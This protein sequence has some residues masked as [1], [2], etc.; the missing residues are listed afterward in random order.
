VDFANKYFGDNYALVYKKQGQDP[1]EKKIDKP[2]ITP[3]V[4]NRDSASAFLKEIQASQV[5][6]IEPVFL[7]YEKDLQ[8]LTA[9]SNIPVLY[10]ENTTNDLFTLVYVFEMGNNN[11][12]AMSTAVQ[13]MKYLGTSKKS[14]KEINEE[15]Y[16]L[17][18]YFRVSSGA[19][20]SY[21]T[22]QGLKENMPKAM[23]LFEEIL[24]DAQVN[25]EAYANLAA[26]IIKNRVD[27]KLN[28]GQNFNSL[29]QYAIWGPKSPYTN[30]LSSAELKQ[31]NPQEL[32]DRIHN[33][34]T[35]E[36]KILYYGP[37]KPE[38]VLDIIKQYHN[39]PE[40]LQ[41]VPAG[42]TFEQQETPK[43][44]VLL[45][46]YDAKQIYFSAISN[47]G[48][49]FDPAIQPTL[50]MYNEY[51]GGGMNAI[52][53][54]EM[55][56]ARGLAYSAGAFMIVPSKLKYPYVYRTF[57]ATQNDKMIDAMKAF[58]EI[59][60]NMP[61]SEKAFNLAKEAMITRLRTDRVTKAEVLWSYLDAQDLGLTTDSRKDLYEKIQT[62]TLPEI[63]AFQEKW[64]KD[65]TY[66]YCILGD[67]KDL[68]IKSL[69]K[70]GP[71]QRVTKEELFGY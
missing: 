27:A 4:M 28:Q 23:A 16:R 13:Y 34:N 63:K 57:I 38:A 70:Y 43:S 42:I 68:D 65:R 8:K 22:L 20:R 5:A 44:K 36:H 46:Q 52:V 9:K 45:A 51:L 67:E 54:Q 35:F 50:D 11:D 56:E 69:S 21:V 17:A 24:A 2:Q 25:K 58:D 40:Q 19:E 59:I 3:I 6:P 32:V 31:M 30:V 60:N 64:V 55:R 71:I 18:C 12:K 53:F 39:V 37:E 10:K 66:I 15:F 47:R 1:N 29:V 48:E 61:E 62:M 14:L 26:D 7:D 49:K 41:P 33:I